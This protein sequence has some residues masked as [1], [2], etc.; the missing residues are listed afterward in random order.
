MV[1]GTPPVILRPPM[2]LARRMFAAM[3][4]KRLPVV[5]GELRV[6]GTR[7]EIRIR[8]DPWGIPH[9]EAQD[10]E[11]AWF[12]VGFCQG[13]D[14]TFQLQ[15]LKRLASGRLSELVGAG[16]LPVD[17]LSRRIGFRRVAEQQLAATP[18]RLR[19][20]FAAYARGVNAGSTQGLGGRRPHE[21]AL[22]RAD[23]VPFEAADVLAIMGVQSFL[24]ASNWDMELARLTILRAD[25]PEAL[26]A[27]DSSYPEWA[28]VS[29]APSVRAGPAA[30][31]LAHDLARL[32]AEA[33]GSGASN[34]WALRSSRTATGR[35]LLANDPHL[36]PLLPPHWYFVHVKTPTWG[37]AGAAFIGGPAIPAGHNGHAAW[38][39][40]AGFIDNT[41]LFVEE[42]GPDRRSVKVGD[43]YE[44]CECIHEEIR[45]K[46]ADPVVEEV[47]VTRHGPIVGPAFNGEFGAISMGATWFR[48]DPVRG[49]FDIHRARSFEGFRDAFRDWPSVGLNM[50][51]ADMDDTVG[52][53]MVGKVPRRRTPYATLPLDGSDPAVGWEDDVVPFD[54]M[55]HASNPDDGFVA[56]ANNKPIEDCDLHL[57]VDWLDGYRLARIVERLDA[58]SDW[59]VRSTQALQVDRYSIPWRQLR[60]RVLAVCQRPSLRRARPL[61]ETWDGQVL[62]DSPAATLFELF[63]VEMCRRV[64]AA[65]AP[66]SYPWVLGRGFSSISPT[67]QMG[68]RR[69]SHLVRLVDSNA[70]GWFERSWD[71]EMAEAMR[72]TLRHLDETF[73][74]EPQ[75]WAWGE[76]R[77]ITMRHPLGRNPAFAPVF[78]IGPLHFGG[79]TNT[80]AQLSV[81]MNGPLG[82][83]G[84]IPS[85][86]F[87]AD[88]GDWDAVR[89][90]LPGGQSGNPCS[91][92]YEDL[93]EP[94][95][96]GEGVPLSWTERAVSEVTRHTL[97]LQPR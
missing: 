2:S 30:D 59:D 71:D 31:R 1:V 14:R 92:H 90:S 89:I 24:L 66:R 38:G 45:V 69:V 58:R 21:F 47:L 97:V 27:L 95:L 40:T 56:T 68:L 23:P 54:Q 43:V 74:F 91:P 34:N 44:A 26:A 9:I 39:L 51:Y 8:R 6:P 32:A 65:K 93:V 55:P 41:D 53:Q 33:G 37:V 82:D 25:G 7:G 79:N 88:V 49:I 28:P 17:R 85:M 13:Q 60:D 52:W 70:T 80:V 83:P 67:S 96:R 81:N 12:G 78:N 75:D 94:W 76:A 11:D 35:P 77:P 19:L 72:A 20:A 16:A 36:S 64:A 15:S 10:D 84:A 50:V 62:P 3:L 48:A 5:S 73:G 87:V 4:G 29:R 61:L 46:G 57:G 63:V 18:E 22:L 42:L 86:R